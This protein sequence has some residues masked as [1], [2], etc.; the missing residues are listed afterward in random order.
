MKYQKAVITGASS[1]IG[2]TFARELASQK[3]DLILVARREDL[4]Q[5]LALELKASFNVKIEILALDLS[6]SGSAQKLFDFATRDDQKIDLLVNNAGI[7]PYRMFVKT[8][9]ADHKNVIQLNLVTLTEATY[10][11][12]KH[13]LSHGKQSSILNVSSVASYQPIPRFAVYCASKS[14]VRYFSEILRYELK[15]TNVN[16]SCLCPGGT[17]TEFLDKNNQSLKSKL[18][19]LMPTRN[20]VLVALNGLERKRAVII[21]GIMNKMIVVGLSLLPNSMN[22]RMSQ[23]AMDIVVQETK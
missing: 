22:L 17:K 11:F 18:N 15:N 23:L 14:Y 19:V 3:T 4:L 20:V 6:E 2:E 9:L 8:E 5:K 12:A 13:M 21:P 10:L 7:G 16:V 1:G